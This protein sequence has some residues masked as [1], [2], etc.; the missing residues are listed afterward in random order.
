M[1]KLYTILYILLTFCNLRLTASAIDHDRTMQFDHLTRRS[2]SELMSLARDYKRNHQPD[3]AAIVAHIVAARYDDSRR[4]PDEQALAIEAMGMLGNIYRADYSDYPRAFTYLNRAFHLSC[5]HGLHGE[6]AY[7]SVALA[8]LYEAELNTTDQPE[9]TDTVVSLLRHAYATAVASASWSEVVS[10]AYNM[11]VCGYARGR[12]ADVETDLR[13]FCT[14]PIP[15]DVRNLDYTRRFCSGIVALGQR[16][17]DE[18]LQQFELMRTCGDPKDSL[19]HEQTYLANCAEV[20]FQTGQMDRALDYMYRIKAIVEREDNKYDLMQVYGELYTYYAKMGDERQADEARLNYLELKTQVQNIDRLKQI[21]D[22]RFLNQIDSMTIQLDRLA[23]A[24]RAQNRMLLMVS[25]VALVIALILV[26]LVWAY[27]QL[28]HSHE[29]LYEKNRQLMAAQASALPLPA[30]P[31][32]SVAAPTAAAE[33]P[34]PAAE[35]PAVAKYQSNQLSQEQTDRI[36]IKLRQAM[37]DTRLICQTD[38]SLRQLADVIG[39]RQRDVSQVINSKLGVNFHTLL[40]E[41]RVRE[42]CRLIDTTDAA[43]TMTIE[44]L[45]ERV[46]MQSRSNFAVAFKRTTGLNPSAYIRISK[47]KKA[48]QN[49]PTLTQNAF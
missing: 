15:A 39:E 26:W 28:R 18:A 1:R 9:L 43:T 5:Q 13:Q 12:M 21:K 33:A 40:G 36:Y 17:Y 37:Q 32:P 11:A 45:A 14:L 27:R 24:H 20:Y 35:A 2:S 19:T 16:R 41:Y 25:L 34:H 10:S 31:K 47:S 48:E 44:G 8:L 46:G 23:E 22:I 4:R 38:F 42:A 7:V 30:E 3:S 6:E 29:A 49:P